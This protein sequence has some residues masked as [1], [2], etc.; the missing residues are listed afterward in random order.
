MKGDAI[1][2]DVSGF[3]KESGSDTTEAGQSSGSMPMWVVDSDAQFLFTA[4]V[5]FGR[6]HADMP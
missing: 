5:L 4:Q 6:L 3:R 2:P 1:V